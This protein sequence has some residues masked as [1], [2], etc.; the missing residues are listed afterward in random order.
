MSNIHDT[1]TGGSRR[2]A[3]RR[4]SAPRTLTIVMG[5]LCVSDAELG[6]RIGETRQ[7]IHKKRTGQA[8]ITTDNIDDYATALDIEP[9]VLLRRPSAALAWLVE[10]RSDVLDGATALEHKGCLVLVRPAGTDSAR[11]AMMP[12]PVGLRAAA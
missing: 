11:R 4:S 3:S 6:R 2:G 10:H 7:N 12:V 8:A 9:E 5:A 1:Q